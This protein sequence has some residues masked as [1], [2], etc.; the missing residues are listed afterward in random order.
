MGTKLFRLLEGLRA[1][2]WFLPSVLA[3]AAVLLAFASLA[4]DRLIGPEWFRQF[5]WFHIGQPEGTRDLLSTVAGSM[6]TVTGV[7]YSITIVAL[8]L[9]SQ[10]FGPRLLYN[11]MRDRGNQLVLGT[12][13]ATYLYCLLIIRSISSGEQDFAPHLSEIVGLLLAIVSLGVLIYFIHHVAESIQANNIITRVSSELE[14]LIDRLFPEQPPEHAHDRPLEKLPPSFAR[15]AVPVRSTR[16]GYLQAIDIPGL[17]ALASREDLLLR[18]LVRPGEF[19]VHEAPLALLYPWQRDGEEELADRINS[20]FIIGSR[21]TQDQDVKLLLNELVEMAVRALSP[22]INDPFTA[23]SCSD[24]LGAALALLAGRPLHFP[25]HHDR[26]KRLRV[27]TKPPTY[28]DLVGAS[29]D[30]IRQFCRNNPQVTNSLL[31]AIA[32]SL[33]FTQRQEQRRALL[34]QAEMIRRGSREGLPEEADRQAVEERYQAILALGKE[35]FG[36]ESS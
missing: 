17:V 9:A 27:I 36:L 28:A 23:I 31:T 21:R 33:E 14:K 29:F 16:Q 5:S 19:L 34:Q 6:I 26:K 24:H 18:L 10:Q 30:Q 12:F 35:K 25:F 2:Y 3:A 7:V 8:S 1:N 4:L 13:L 11:F 15:K 32:R 22:G 20:H